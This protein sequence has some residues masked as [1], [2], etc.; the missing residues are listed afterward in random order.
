MGLA[1]A[2]EVFRDIRIAYGL[3]FQCR[4]S[5]F[6]SCGFI[7]LL[8]QV[9]VDPKVGIGLNPSAELLGHIF[10]S[11]LTVQCHDLIGAYHIRRMRQADQRRIQETS[12]VV[13]AGS[14]EFFQDRAA[15]SHVAVVLR[16]RCAYHRLD[17]LQHLGIK[18]RVINDRKQPRSP[19]G[20]ALWIVRQ[21]GYARFDDLV[22]QPM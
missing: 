5:L 18:V 8:D 14:C 2:I 6:K 22:S 1:N 4:E 15:L 19:R 17:R 21:A 3:A 9:I 11:V 16:R 10:Q 7:E 12:R 13:G 20:L